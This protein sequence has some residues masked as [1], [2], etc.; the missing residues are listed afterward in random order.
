MTR[1]AV[2]LEPAPLATP[3]NGG[4]ARM[5]VLAV[6]V[7]G[8]GAALALYAL[9][10]FI[11]VYGGLMPSIIALMMEERAGRHL[12]VTVASFNGAGLMIGLEPFFSSTLSNPAAYQIVSAPKTWLLIYG[13]ALAGWVLT[14]ILPLFV[15]HGLDLIDR[16]RVRAIE[17]ARETI[18]KQWPSIAE[19][20]AHD[21]ANAPIPAMPKAGAAPRQPRSTSA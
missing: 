4:R 5:L 11:L 15:S 3:A 17:L 7:S 20:S 9:P 6:G 21:L 13:F 1:R 10:I 12:T 16:Q 2:D 18:V 14:W 8:L 19:G